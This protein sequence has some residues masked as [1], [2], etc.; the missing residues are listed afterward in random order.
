MSEK[1][2]SSHPHKSIQQHTHAWVHT[3]THTPTSEDFSMGGLSV[4][5][6]TEAGR[7]LSVCKF[8][9]VCACVCVPVVSWIPRWQPPRNTLQAWHRSEAT[10]VPIQSQTLILKLFFS[11]RFPLGFRWGVPS[12]DRGGG[13]CLGF[14]ISLISLMVTFMNAWN[15]VY[16]FFWSYNNSRT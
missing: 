15:Y 6:V 2:T 3:R 12:A 14:K 8:L 13:G 5:M 10:A 9:C 11:K 7:Y 4:S 16:I 1:S